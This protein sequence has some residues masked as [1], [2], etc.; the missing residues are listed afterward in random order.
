[1]GPELTVATEKVPLTYRATRG[2]RIPLG[3]PQAVAANQQFPML[4]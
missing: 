1:M 3:I 2:N 4:S